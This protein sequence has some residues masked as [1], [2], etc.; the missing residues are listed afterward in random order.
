MMKYYETKNSKK[1]AKTGFLF[2]KHIVLH[3]Y[4]HN[5]KALIIWSLVVGA[6]MAMVVLLYPTFKDMYP[7]MIAGLP[8]AMQDIMNAI[9]GGFSNITEFYAAEGGQLYVL[10]GAIYASLL[11]ISLFKNEMVDGSFEFLFTQPVS[12]MKVFRSKLLVLITN[13]FVFNVIVGSMGLIGI[14]LAEGLAGVNIVNFLL[15]S[16]FAFVIHL[17]I[18][19]IVFSL[20]AMLGKKMSTGLGIAVAVLTY[21]VGIISLLSTLASS[22]DVLKYLTPFTYVING[23]IMEGTSAVNVPTLIMWSVIPVLLMVVA[24]IRFKR[25]D[26]I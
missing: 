15:Y 26:I 13:L 16:L 5:A 12:R 18:G 14:H 4:E 25:Q 23:L 10:V 7:E 1:D 11:A 22:L 19:L 8:E 6:L 20:S 2:N 9:G 17:Q 3:Q 21:F 24:H